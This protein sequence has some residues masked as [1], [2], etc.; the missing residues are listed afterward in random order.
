MS[1]RPSFVVNHAHKP[2]SQAFH[3]ARWYGV[4][5]PP[6]PP[7]AGARLIRTLLLHSA[8]LFCITENREGRLLKLSE[9]GGRA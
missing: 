6:P 9:G 7:A 5:S 4:L 3:H 2:F 8:I 1:G